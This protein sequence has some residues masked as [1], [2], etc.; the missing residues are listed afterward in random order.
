MYDILG[1]ASQWWHSAVVTTITSVT[2]DKT[3][4]MNAV[5]GLTSG[6]EAVTGLT[7]GMNAVTGLTKPLT[8]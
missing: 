2:I 3:I 1:L 5:T 4:G 7:R 8:E 6:M